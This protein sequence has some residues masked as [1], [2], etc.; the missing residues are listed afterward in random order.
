M[1]EKAKSLKLETLLKTLGL[2][3][4]KN[5]QEKQSLEHII[6]EAVKRISTRTCKSKNIIEINGSNTN[7]LADIV[8][9]AK[10]TMDGNAYTE[11]LE[12]L[13]SEIMKMQ[14]EEIKKSKGENS[15]PKFTALCQGHGS[16]EI[17]NINTRP[18]N[19]R[20][21]AITG[22]ATITKGDYK[23]FIEKYN[24]LG[25]LRLSTRKL[26]DTCAA[27][28]TKNNQYRGNGEVDRFVQISLKEYMQL[29]KKPLTK[30]T[31][32]SVRKRVKEDLEI[33]YFVSI[34]WRERQKGKT[35]DYQKMRIVTSQG[36][37]QGNITIGF[38]P[39]FAH[40]LLNAYVMQYPYAL[41]GLD[42]R[43]A[44]SYSLG[45]RLLL[46]R[47]MDN[48]TRK[49]TANIISIK[50]LL[51]ACPDIPSYEEVMRNDR[52]IDW[53]IK[54]PFENALNALSDFITWATKQLQNFYK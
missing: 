22:A 14:T 48:N 11:F 5:H 51:Q 24:E 28:L 29:L 36:I 47:S 10:N 23:M 52:H 16:N 25:G 30:S 45:R 9:D 4:T 54:T 17:I 50:S 6:A 38:S 49:K 20:I 27:I 13:I 53:R 19:S 33:L 39:E 2:P 7:E 41:L 15:S 32:D 34:E 12:I 37:K 1:D 8:A 40:Y 42:E 26:L 43:N 31:T 35:R 44:N 46:H 3:K 21:D 18:A